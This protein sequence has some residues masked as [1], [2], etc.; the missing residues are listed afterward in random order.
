[1]TLNAFQDNAFAATQDAQ[2]FA[3]AVTLRAESYGHL[4]APAAKRGPAPQTN[5]A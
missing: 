2:A 5:A 1:M 4:A 3:K